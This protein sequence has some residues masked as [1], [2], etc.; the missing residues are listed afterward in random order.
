M[1]P[2]KKNFRTYSR[3]KNNISGVA[4]FNLLLAKNLT[5]KKLS[6][7]KNGTTHRRKNDKI[8]FKELPQ[9]IKSVV[10]D[11]SLHVNL[12]D[13]FDRLR[14]QPVLKKPVYIQMQS[15]NVSDLTDVSEVSLQVQ[16]LRSFKNKS[17]LKVSNNHTT[18]SWF[19]QQTPT[20]E[21]ITNSLEIDSISKKYFNK[22]INKSKVPTANTTSSIVL[23]SHNQSL[24]KSTPIK[25][26][27]EPNCN[28]VV[29]STI[30]EV[31]NSTHYG[32]PF[33]GKDQPPLSP[34]VPKD[35]PELKECII[36][37]LKEI[38]SWSCSSQF[39]DNENKSKRKN[40][41]TRTQNSVTKSK[42]HSSK[43]DKEKCIS[44]DQFSEQDLSAVSIVRP[45]RDFEQFE[46]LFCSTFNTEVSSFL[47]SEDN[48]FKGFITDRKRK[49]TTSVQK[50]MLKDFLVV[51]DRSQINFSKD[52]LKLPM[53]PNYILKNKTK[54]RT[55]QLTI[56]ITK[57]SLTQ[58][59]AQLG[60]K[61][62]RRRLSKR[63]THSKPC[64]KFSSNS[65]ILEVLPLKSDVK[66]TATERRNDSV[67]SVKSGKNGL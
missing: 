27:K 26:N 55:K 28:V 50:K 32:S 20:G 35:K 41:A 48:Q 12:D 40:I 25:L 17:L 52:R 6:K 46:S 18:C 49:L 47:D 66:Q 42:K 44:T 21:A 19:M 38:K 58:F 33:F 11:E 8:E 2:Y 61:S 51:L 31:Y 13:T 53:Q 37:S 9:L 57:C 54:P 45:L 56:N 36:E 22:S 62:E 10:S 59:K 7:Q 23:R 63:L 24:P 64:R 65:R 4:A 15:S 34:I 5:Q 1:A 67:D 39:L 43:G 60:R 16:K 29:N 14:K 30:K 3:S